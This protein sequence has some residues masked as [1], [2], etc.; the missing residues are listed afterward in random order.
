MMDTLWG[1][2]VDQLSPS[3]WPL[4]T[5]HLPP[6]SRHR[7]SAERSSEGPG[8]IDD[9]TKRAVSVSVSGGADMGAE[10]GG[11]SGRTISDT[12]IKRNVGTWLS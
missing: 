10:A 11:R 9:M 8:A 6:P 7:S 4:F 1:F 2:D 3:W 12:A 5:I